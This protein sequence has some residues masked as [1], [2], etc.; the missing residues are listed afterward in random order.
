MVGTPKENSLKRIIPLAAIRYEGE[1][2]V[3]AW[4][5]K[6]RNPTFRKQS[7]RGIIVDRTTADSAD[8]LSW[9]LILRGSEAADAVA[10]AVRVS[11]LP[12]AEGAAAV[13]AFALLFALLFAAV[14]D[15]LARPAAVLPR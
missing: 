9:A 10:V 14:A 11:A 3:E 2:R 12:V 6:R 5:M 4:R 15:A 13:R 8:D 7:E 1:M